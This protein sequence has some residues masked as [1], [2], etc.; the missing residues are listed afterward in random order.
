MAKSQLGVFGQLSAKLLLA[1]TC[2]A[3]LSSYSTAQDKPATPPQFVMLAFDG[4][5]DNKFWA[6]SRD[7]AKASN[8][9]FTYFVSCTYYLADADRKI[10]VEPRNG[11]GK[12]TI[13]WG[14]KP[15]DIAERLKQTA[16][17]KDEGNEIASTILK[18]RG[19]WLVMD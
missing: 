5:W 12:S 2:L 18:S 3:A 10:Y 13:G 9:H 11:P 14:G 8:L 16:A 1:A 4:G 7:F 17:A 6:E 19:C 15:A